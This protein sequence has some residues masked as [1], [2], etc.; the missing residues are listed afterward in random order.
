[1]QNKKRLAKLFLA[2]IIVLTA[3]VGSAQAER[4]PRGKVWADCE[5]YET[6]GTPA[7]FDGVH[8]PYDR[9]FVGTMF[10]DGVGA[11]S[12][13]KQGDR[14]FNGGRWSVYTLKAGVAMDKYADACSVEDLDMNDFE[15]AGV[16]FECPLLP[17]RGHGRR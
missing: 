8:G 12:E 11:I 15:E 14:D 17:L 10:R 2:G 3:V 13:T 5:L 4:P 1:M 16:Y 6:F 7:E 9:I